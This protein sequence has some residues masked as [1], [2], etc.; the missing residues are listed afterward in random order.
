M[1][2]VTR[3]CL[4]LLMLCLAACDEATM[5]AMNAS[6]AP[7]EAPDPARYAAL[8]DNGKHIRAI[9]VEEVPADFLRQEVT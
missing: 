1:S 6:S 3:L 9:P 7:L 2:F 5:A 8:T 4:P